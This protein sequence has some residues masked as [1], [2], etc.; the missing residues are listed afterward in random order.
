MS[1]SPSPLAATT[2]ENQKLLFNVN[3]VFDSLNPVRLG[4]RPPGLSK[5]TTQGEFQSEAGNWAERE[6]WSR[7][8]FCQRKSMDA[9]VLL[10]LTG[11]LISL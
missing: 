11:S 9:K 6:P 5:E 2:V 1:R 3:A 8:C 4:D 10:L 7:R